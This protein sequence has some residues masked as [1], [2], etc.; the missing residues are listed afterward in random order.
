MRSHLVGLVLLFSIVSN[1][2]VCTGS[3]GD[4]IIKF[5]FGAGIDLYGPPLPNGV[6]DLTYVKNNCPEGGSAGSYAIV[7]GPGFDCFNGDWVNFAADHTPEDPDGFFMLIHASNSPS[8]FFVQAVDGLCPSTSYQV[9]ASIM[10]MASRSGEVPPNL[11]FSIEQKDGTLIQRFHT[12]DV[13]LVKPPQWWNDYAFYF[14]TP[15]GVSSV[16]IRITNNALGGNGNS[17]ALDDIVFRTSGPT[18]NI[19]IDGRSGDSAVLCS[20]TANTL[21]FT[22]TVASCYASTSYQWQESID[23]GNTWSNVEGAV[24]ATYTAHPTT[25]GSALYRLMV[26]QMGNIGMAACQ[27]ASSPDAVT[28]LETAHPSVT[29]GM[30]P[31]HVCVDSVANFSAWIVDG[32]TQPHYQWTVNGTGTGGDGPAYTS[33]TLADGDLVSC[34]LT[35]SAVCAVS[36]TAASNTV[37]I[38]HLPNILSSLKI[39]AS[40][41]NICSDSVVVFDAAPVNGGIAP[42]FAWLINGQPVGKDTV[43]LVSGNLHDGDLVRAI[44]T[45]GMSCSAP[46]M[47]NAVA[48]TVYDAPRVTLISDTMIAPGSYAYLRPVITGAYSRFS[49]APVIGLNNISLLDPVASPRYTT[50]Y[51]ITV[52]NSN[53]CSGKAFEKVEVFDDLRM[54]NAFTP[55]GDGRNDLFRVPASSPLTIKRFSIYNRWGALLFSAGNGLEGWD[56]SV[57]GHAQPPGTYIWTVEY[58]HPILQQTMMKK[59]VFE[60]IR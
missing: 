2:Q 24:N 27:V 29:I 54:P 4:P 34:M 19:N 41:N 11:T 39:S 52:T 6:T 22:S 35:S 32:G 38:Q 42:S 46:V 31:D 14:T 36:P 33:A 23:Q 5:T 16:V 55:N 49:W 47:S 26:A 18:V 50:L 45:T 21:Q 60:L 56:G 59:G 58:Y 30:V 57:Q 9:G 40:A 48:M 25:S 43:A 3:F 53:G 51:Q 13:P 1:A 12:G 15:P 10:N 44:M 8:D 7:H 28:V 20:N 17:L 37:V